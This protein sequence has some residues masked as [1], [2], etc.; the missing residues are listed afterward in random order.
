MDTRVFGRSAGLTMVCAFI[1]PLSSALPTCDKS[2]I[3]AMFISTPSGVWLTHNWN[4]DGA[5]PLI[6]LDPQ[7]GQHEKTEGSQLTP[8]F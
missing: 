3:V 2:H 6:F 4:P 1:L 5:R 7:P 8:R